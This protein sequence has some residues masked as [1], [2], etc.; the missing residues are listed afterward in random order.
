[1]ARR[2]ATSRSRLRPACCTRGVLKLW[3]KAEIS[4]CVN[5]FSEAGGRHSVAYSGHLTKGFGV[6]RKNLMIVEVVIVQE[7]KVRA[8]AILALYCRVVDLRNSRVE[9]SVSGANHQRPFISDRVC[10]AGAR[11]EVVRVERNFARVRP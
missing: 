4:D 10:Q 8:Q 7:E 3:A 5:C 9:H 1:M 6:L 2:W 11:A